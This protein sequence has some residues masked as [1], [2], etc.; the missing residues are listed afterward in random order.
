MNNID[1]V[2]MGLP[3]KVRKC[4]LCYKLNYKWEIAETAEEIIRL[5]EKI[6]KHKNIHKAV[7]P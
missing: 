2:L 3:I 5:E 7:K 1:R 4:Q 6:M